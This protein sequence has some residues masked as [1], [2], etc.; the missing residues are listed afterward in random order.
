METLEGLFLKQQ[1]KPL[2]VFFR[3]QR[4]G[5]QGLGLSA[6]GTAPSRARAGNTPTSQ[7]NLPNL[8]ERAVRRPPR[9]D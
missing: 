8:V 6:C 7:V 2:L 4:G 1:V 9:G 5:G 3:S